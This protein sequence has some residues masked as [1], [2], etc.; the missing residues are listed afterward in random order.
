MAVLSTA[1]LISL[2]VSANAGAGQAIA[3]KTNATVSDDVWVAPPKQVAATAVVPASYQHPSRPDGVT[4]TPAKRPSP[5]TDRPAAKPGGTGKHGKPGNTAKPDK[6]DAD[7]L[8]AGSSILNTGS[9][10][11]EA[12]AK[13]GGSGSSALTGSAGELASGSAALAGPLETVLKAL[14]KEVG[15]VLAQGLVQLLTGGNGSP[16]P[17]A[18][19]P[20][21]RHATVAPAEDNEWSPLSLGPSN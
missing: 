6:G 3:N 20:K 5:R 19:S 13:G 15:P 17:K 18:P 7:L 10:A 4:P 8:D 1:T 14:A 12:L 16:S 9:S 2:A 21:A 11:L